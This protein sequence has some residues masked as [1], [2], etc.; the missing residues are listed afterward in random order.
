MKTKQFIANILILFLFLIQECFCTPSGNSSNTLTDSGIWVRNYPTIS[1]GLT[2]VLIKIRLTQPGKV[3]YVFYDTIETGISATKIKSDA[4]GQSNANIQKCGT[5]AYPTVPSAVSI[6]VNGFDPEQKIYL[7]MVTESNTDGLMEQDI[8]YYNFSMHFKHRIVPLDS[9]SAPYGYLEYLPENYSKDS[10]NGFPLVIFLHGSGGVGNGRYDGLTNPNTCMREGLTR[11]LELDMDL[12]AVVISPQ[13]LSWVPKTL[14]TFIDYLKQHYNVNPDKITITGISMGG[15]GAWEYAI[16]YPEKIA[17]VV[18]LCGAWDGYGSSNYSLLAKTPVWAFHN[19]KDPTVPVNSTYDNIQGIIKAGGHPFM[20]IFR[21][22]D[23]SCAYE[24]YYYP[25]LWYWIFAQERG[26][27]YVQ[28]GLINAYKSNQP[29]VIDGSFDENAWKQD[30]SDIPYNSIDKSKADSKFKLLWNQNYLFAGI[31]LNKDAYS[32]T[33]KDIT[34][35]VNGNNDM[36]GNYDPFDFKFNFKNSDNSV[37]SIND[38]TG[39]IYKWTDTDTSYNFEFA[40]PFSKT[41]NSVPITGDGFGFDIQINA[42]DTGLSSQSTVFWKGNLQDTS[43]TRLFGNI[44]LS[45]LSNAIPTDIQPSNKALNLKLLQN[46]PDPFSQYST[47]SYSIPEK[48]WVT[49]KVYDLS[50]KEVKTLVNQ[51]QNE[52]TYTIQINASD[53]S[54]GIYLY[55]LKSGKYSLSRKFAVVK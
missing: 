47:I 3:Y 7:Y 43:D 29:M 22:D 5:I 54:N 44:L 36:L 42:P 48:E 12:P 15:G 23:H 4:I 26:K 37:S 46:Y 16:T 21:S 2:A 38:T 25:H 19:D 10:I 49:L 50:G 39:I 20:S 51:L 33:E 13:A 11:Y 24:A 35:Y 8:K 14:D 17:A 31:C 52:G 45:Q 34:I 40:F 53:Y 9:T 55:C 41:L 6:Q 18:P 27:G 28:N 32:N 30:W 1:K